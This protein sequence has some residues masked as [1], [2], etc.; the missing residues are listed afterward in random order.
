MTA[1]HSTDQIL[2][3]LEEEIWAP[4][5]F[6]HGTAEDPAGTLRALASDDD[7][8]VREALSSFWHSMRARTP[9]YSATRQCVPYLARLCAAGVYTE[10]LLELL[11][12][13]ADGE[14]Q[15]R[16]DQDELTAAVAT[17]VPA[18]LPL[19]AHDDPDIR[20]LLLRIIGLSGPARAAAEAIRERWP[21]ESDEDLRSEL[22]SA[23]RAADPGIAA[24]IAAGELG[25]ENDP[26]VRLAAALSLVRDDAPWTDE[27]AAAATAWATAGAGAG[28]E[29][30]E[31]WFDTST[32]EWKDTDR[33]D[34]AFQDLLLLLADRDGLPLS[35]SLLETARTAGGAAADTVGDPGDGAGF[36][37]RRM[38][39][40]IEALCGEFRPAPA[41][42]T[43]PLAELVAHADPV[44]RGRAVAMVRRLGEEGR[45]AA[46]AVLAVAAG[47]TPG[48]GGEGD[49]KEAA[50]D[51][52]ALLVALRD[53]RAVPL[54]ARHLPHSRG[55]LETAV[56]TSPWSARRGVV[57]PFDAA[58]LAAARSLLRTPDRR[59]YGAPR[60][61]CALLAAWG[62]RAAPALPE[63]Y[64]LLSKEPQHAP[65]AVAAVAAGTPDAEVAADR[66]RAAADRATSAYE[67]M[68]AAVA[69]REL[70]DESGLLVAAVRAGLDEV[71][72]SKRAAVTRARD[73]GP[74]GAPLL[75]RLR[76][77]L[78][79]E[80]SGDA[81]WDWGDCLGAA[82]ATHAIHGREA[83][84]ELL[85]TL[86]AALNGRDDRV[87]DAAARLARRI[88]APAAALASDIPPLFGS[89]TT[90]VSACGA[91]LAF[92]GAVVGHDSAV[93]A[94]EANDVDGADAADGVDGVDEET[95]TDALLLAVEQSGPVEE[96]LGLLRELG[97]G[98][99]APQVRERLRELA[100][101][102]RRPPRHPYDLQWIR[103]DQER[104]AALRTALSL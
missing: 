85:P 38:L 11:H 83:A 20:R 71:L 10:T 29:P 87:R 57:V 81:G 65:G 1:Q 56:G 51:A 34:T 12:S 2:A 100:G 62:P 39:S 92:P 90:L 25:A 33:E 58:L 24:D 43:G 3:G 55:A 46:D 78:T 77:L 13:V 102:P 99:L 31:R 88:G 44:V 41:A 16:G 76:E 70:T 5:G 101:S 27:L 8:A 21:Q 54:L 68:P 96:A 91:L 53:P 60:H 67:R 98:S 22:L 75:P 42:L 95:V 48:S 17:Q 50:D 89:M 84:G 28:S 6:V 93:G 97:G 9:A 30:G 86:S 14:D 35:L 74:D 103:K 82:S 80:T 36:R 73:L 15:P 49:D 4:T 19:L 18:L 26:E 59:N 47:E 63:L 104:L 40:G 61:L 23:C 69:L 64:E 45:P 72:Y 7:E 52:L 94:D 66:L 32:G 79:P 37:A